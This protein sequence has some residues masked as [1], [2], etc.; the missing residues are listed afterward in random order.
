MSAVK[1]LCTNSDSRKPHAAI[2]ACNLSEV[3]SDIT[4]PRLCRAFVWEWQTVGTRQPL[5]GA[6][7]SVH[8]LFSRLL[9][10]F[11]ISLTTHWRHFRFEIKPPVSSHTSSAF[12]GVLGHKAIQEENGRHSHPALAQ[13]GLWGS[14]PALPSLFCRDVL[15]W[16]VRKRAQM[17]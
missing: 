11:I 14:V 2:H 17:G 13:W 6:C 5:F 16:P 8:K 3:I 15:V 7:N 10:H 9:Q 1:V 4:S 12:F